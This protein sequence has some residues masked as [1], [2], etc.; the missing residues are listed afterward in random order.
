LGVVGRFWNHIPKGLKPESTSQNS[1]I[2]FLPSLSSSSIIIATKF[3][4]V[5]TKMKKQGLVMK[6]KH[7]DGDWYLIQ[8]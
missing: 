5:I 2:P 6:L 4:L 3:G 8:A 7:E 1:S